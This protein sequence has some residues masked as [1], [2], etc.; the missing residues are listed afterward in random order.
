MYK[1]AQSPIPVC[2]VVAA[3]RTNTWVANRPPIDND[4][5]D[6]TCAPNMGT[7]GF[8]K[9]VSQG[10]FYVHVTTH[11]NKFLCNKTN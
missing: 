2:P 7:L 10:F 4:F 5:Y 8:I 11:R 1:Y 3:D 9:T 6:I